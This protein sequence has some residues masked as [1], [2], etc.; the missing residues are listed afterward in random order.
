MQTDTT[1]ALSRAALIH[2][3]L[4]RAAEKSGEFDSLN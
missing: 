2:H 4:E 3:I 1:E